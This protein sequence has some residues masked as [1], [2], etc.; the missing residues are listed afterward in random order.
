MIQ[1]IAIIDNENDEAAL[2]SLKSQL[3]EKNSSLKQQDD[4]ILELVSKE[5]GEEGSGC[6]DEVNNAGKFLQMTET[7]IA[8]IRNKLKIIQQPPVLQYT[9]IS[10]ERQDSIFSVESLSSNS[11]SVSVK[12][13]RLKLRKLE[14]KKFSGRTVDWPEFWDRLKTAVHENEELSNAEKLSYLR[15]Y[16]E[17]PAKKVISGLP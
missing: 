4:E 16:L 1:L 3:E 17:E 11:S 15:H 14:L 9:P 12:R 13:V 8:K 5:E 7:S 6:A 2:E 10:Y